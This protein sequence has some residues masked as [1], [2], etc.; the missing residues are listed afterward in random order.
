MDWTNTLNPVTLMPWSSQEEHDQFWRLPQQERERLIQASRNAMGGSKPS[1][2]YPNQTC[3]DAVLGHLQAEKDRICNAMPGASC[4][5]SGKSA[6]RLARMPCS[7][8]RLRIQALQNCIHIRQFIQDECFG[9]VPDTPHERAL[10]EHKLGLAHCLALE[11]ENCAPGHPMA[12][13]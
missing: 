5:P 7:Q 11:A 8:I 3:D 1:R 6:R 12:D 13:F 2:R 9:G 10:N 4:S